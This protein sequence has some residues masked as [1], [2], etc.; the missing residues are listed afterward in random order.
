MNRRAWIGAM[1][2]AALAPALLRAQSGPKGRV[3]L[4][5]TGK[6]KTGGDRIGRV[7]LDQAALLALPQQS[8][9]TSTPWF[10]APR[11]FEGPALADVL[12]RIGARGDTLFATAL[13]DY[14]IEIPVSDATA[15][16]P[17]V[18]LKVDGRFIGVREKGPLWIVYDFDANPV[19]HDERYYSRSIWQLRYLDVR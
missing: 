19:L 17:I 5:V 10:A 1:A 18:A 6:L 15:F 2:A 12:S 11:Q 3:L 14:R 7:E 8:F 16:R 4:T 9:S 13:N